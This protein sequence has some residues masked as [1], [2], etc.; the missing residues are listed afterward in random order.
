MFSRRQL[1]G[2]E[3][4]SRSTSLSPL[5]LLWGMLCLCSA[6][7]Q[8]NR[9]AVIPPPSGLFNGPDVYYTPPAG[10]A[11]NVPFRPGT[12][13]SATNGSAISLAPNGATGTASRGSASTTRSSLQDTYDVSSRVAADS[14]PIRVLD[15]T[16][17]NSSSHAT[18]ARGMPVN[19]GTNATSWRTSPAPAT[20]AGN[21]F[22]GLR[23]TMA[24]TR[25]AAPQ[26]LS[27]QD[28]QW[29]SRSSYEATER[30]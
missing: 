4:M 25:S 5:L 19:D 29:R 21:P 17:R 8:N 10:A 9:T 20:I 12:T 6:G 27:G 24:D 26:G 1:E 30:R 18:V 16:T 7:C 22:G 13:A 3:P 11:T 23:G 2:S 15:A 14:Q 28:G